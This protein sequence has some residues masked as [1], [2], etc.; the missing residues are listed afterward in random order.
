MLQS[1]TL[2]CAKAEIGI[3]K[4]LRK[5]VISIQIKLGK[6]F[7]FN[8]NLHLISTTCLCHFSSIQSRI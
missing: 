6:V 2:L 7:Y 4:I 1:E 3:F 8:Y 5:K